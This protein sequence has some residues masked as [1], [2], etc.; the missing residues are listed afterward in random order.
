MLSLPVPSGAWPGPYPRSRSSAGPLPALSF[1]AE[2]V[3]VG[4]SEHMAKVCDASR[5]ASVLLG[6]S[7]KESTTQ[8]CLRA[9]IAA[10]GRCI[11]VR[12]KGHRS[13]D[14]HTADWRFN[15]VKGL[16]SVDTQ[17]RQLID[18]AKPAIN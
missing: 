13:R 3:D 7:R 8:L 4:I 17:K 16:A 10:P 15:M 12:A 6:L 1:L 2:F 18:T 11:P 5:T 9:T 14:P